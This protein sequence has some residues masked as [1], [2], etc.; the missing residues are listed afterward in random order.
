VPSRLSPPIV[1]LIAASLLASCGG[2][3]TGGEPTVAA[4]ATPILPA[5]I[6]S[7][8]PTRQAQSLAQIRI[9]FHEP[10]AELGALVGD[11]P[12]DVLAR[13]SIVPALPGRFVLFTPRMVGF[14]PERALPIGTRVRV[15]LASGLRDLRGDALSRDLSWT[16]Q[17]APLTFSNFPTDDN[18]E[19]G[20]TPPP[21]GLTPALR[22]TASAQVDPALLAAH[23][24][25]IAGP[26]TIPLTVTPVATPSAFP[27]TGAAVA[28]D[29]S[30]QTW[31]YALT[32]QRELAKDTAYQLRIDPGVLPRNGNVATTQASIG[33]IHT[34]AALDVVP[35]PQP[36]PGT[37]G[38]F[39][40]GDPVI[41]VNN[42]LDLK[43]VA[44]NVTIAPATGSSTALTSVDSYTP[45]VV[46]IDPYLLSP[47]STYVVTL[48]SGLKDAFGQT[49]GRARSIT[50]RTGDFAPGFWAPSGVNIFPAG[51]NVSLNA[52]ATNVT[53]NSYRLFVGDVSPESLAA[54][55]TVPPNKL[56]DDA[57]WMGSEIRGAKTNAQAVIPF[58]LQT[59]VGGPTGTI[60][61]GLTA[62]VG[63][64]DTPF[65]GVVQLTDLG[66]FAQIFPTRAVIMVQRLTDGSAVG[67]AAIRVYRTGSTVAAGVC[68]TGTTDAGGEFDLV[69][70]ALASCYAG[71]RDSGEAPGIMVVASH[72]ADWSYVKVD[73]WAGIYRYNIGDGSW[74]G[75]APL[76]R[77]TIFSDRQMYQPGESAKVTGVAYFV[78]DGAVVA[79]TNAAYTLSMSDPQNHTTSLGSVRTDAYGVFSLTL[80][81][82]ANQA[83]GYYALAATGSNG[84]QLTGSLRVAEFKP[85]NFKLDLALDKSSATAG[86]S[87]NAAA[88]ASYLFGAPLDGGTATVNV[89][90]DVATLAPTGWDDYTFGRQW[91]WP[92]NQPEF[93]SDVLQTSATFDSA[94]K[95][96]QR[97]DVPADLPFPMT[98]TVDVQ[99]SDIS[100]LTVDNSQTFTA[101]GSDAT[102]GL[103]TD[104][105]GQAGAPLNVSAIVTTPDGKTVPS[106][107]IHVELQKMSYAAATQIVAGG[108]QA[109]N[110]VS[111]ATVDTADATVGGKPASIALHPTDSGSYRLRANFAGSTNGASETDLQVFVAG[112][113][114][115]DWGGQDNTVAQ[116]VL[117]KKTYRVGDTATA[118]VASPYARSDVYFAIVR[119]NVLSKTVVHATG[120]GVKFSF[121]VTP[122]MIPNVALEALVVRRGLPLKS[123]KA[124]ALDS[125]AR[126]GV[127]AVHVALGDRYLKVT[128][129]P[130]RAMLQ[131][132]SHQ[133]VNLRVRDASGQPARG[134]AIVMVVNDA[135]LQLTGYRPPDLVETIFADQPISTRFADNRSSV[136][137]TTATPPSEKGWGYGGGYLGGA[138]STRVRTNFRPLAYYA[139]VPTD[140]IGRAAVSFAL[141][142]DLTTWRVMAVALGSDGAHFGNGE[143]TFIATQPLLTNPLLPQFARPGDLFDGGVSLLDSTTPGTANVSA[144][145]TGAL[146]FASGDPHGAQASSPV[147]AQLTAL[148]FPMIAGTPA[149]TTV[150]FAS[151]LGSAS[152]AMR[153][154]F[155]IGDRQVTQSEI[156]ADAIQGH[157]ALPIDLSRGGTLSL[158]LSNSALAGASVT[159][160]RTLSGDPQPFVD[161]AAGRLTI[162]TA[163]GSLRRYGLHLDIGS[164]AQRASALAAIAK[165]QRDD[166]G[167]GFTAHAKNSDPYE[168]ANAV[169]SLAYAA[170]AGT[171]VDASALARA[172]AYVSRTLAD[173]SRYGWCKDAACEARLRFEMLWTL[174]ALGDRR[175]DFLGDITAQRATFDQATQI[176][177]ARYLLRIPGWQNQGAAQAEELEQTLYRTG[178]YATQSSSSAW[179]WLGSTVD[180]QAQMLA[181][182]VERNADS[183]TQGGAVAALLAQSC[184]CGWPTLADSAEASQALAEYAAHEKLVPFIATI[185]AAGSQLAKITFAAV[186]SGRTIALPAATLRGARTID[187]SAGGG[188]LHYAM[189]YTYPVASNAPGQL[190]GLRVVREVRSAGESATIAT[191]DLAALTDPID[192]AAGNVFD[193]GVR[194]IVDHPIDDVVIE[195]PIP[196]GMEAVDASFATA[197]RT[198][199]AASDSWQID[200]QEIYAD[201]VMAYG[202]HLEPGIYEVHYLARSVTPG[203]YVWPGAHAYLRSAPE[204]FGRTAAATVTV[205]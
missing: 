89:T 198:V 155:T 15:T 41:V 7:I 199:F 55:D 147:A 20:Q 146:S 6:A 67:G 123:L 186:P 102:I 99:A 193:I 80:P 57:H 192:L 152:D 75:G 43:S 18:D 160:A 37:S 187:V 173:P 124:G 191:M 9:I 196:A 119:Q 2:S 120:N 156:D 82:S 30:Q 105:V 58:A 38:R 181:L 149:P 112:A 104:L 93:S 16:F 194:V 139:V 129:T 97:V 170:Q 177:L 151:T 144:S 90:R 108:E 85:P 71:V 205:R 36:S 94:G 14:V 200:D 110:A 109:Q 184:K 10:I 195:D 185:S 143:T 50:V 65:T 73:P 204:Q 157:A 168:T 8:S 161:D 203:T 66:I 83:L 60:S 34:Y 88:T 100:H 113:G 180:A 182:L 52:Y 172:K 79:D 46:A 84:N 150:S 158:T 32:P 133:T 35:T 118:L 72:A 202:S 98:Y 138:G 142:D 77:G 140:S 33:A 61:Y 169:Q 197:S 175:S 164:P 62:D 31:A 92:E 117:D 22:V 167:Y 19:N 115:A 178:R 81:F 78:R 132:G 188:T 47:D 166:G 95:L 87:V 101:L 21:T 86:S 51:A 23:A 59:L 5:W 40:G 137:L 1:T 64:T 114:H 190:A 128:L 28:F 122:A 107:A 27:G 130:Q 145:L 176:R 131:P 25:L 148:R 76:S 49:L 174:D 68:A 96:T 74:V 189:L 11:G 13:F 136:V 53:G 126:V 111:Y 12:S 171:S 42:P 165:A 162:I 56:P 24:R 163:L 103:K 39:A 154:P 91:F 106:R 141:P 54:S 63:G 201:R 4:I 45:N 153:V 127:A 29:P 183:N 135:I 70:P 179:G 44:A 121:K 17:T 125:L 159:L 69:G 116:V 134:E 26:T 48:G 3:S